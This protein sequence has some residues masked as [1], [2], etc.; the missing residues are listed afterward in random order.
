MKFSS[1]GYVWEGKTSGNGVPGSSDT[2]FDVLRVKDVGSVYV[3]FDLF[4][5][6][7]R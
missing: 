7:G 1:G 4:F 5:N 6:F 2:P 3:F